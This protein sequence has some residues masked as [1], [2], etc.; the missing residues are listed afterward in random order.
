[1]KKSLALFLGL[2]AISL[3]WNP[4][5]VADEVQEKKVEAYS[6]EVAKIKKYFD[7]ANLQDYSEFS[8]EGDNEYLYSFPDL[9]EYDEND[10]ELDVEEFQIGSI[11][12]LDIKKIHSIFIYEYCID[13]AFMDMLYL[14][15]DVKTLKFYACTFADSVE[16]DWSHFRSL[17]YLLLDD[18]S[19]V[20][21][22]VLK[23][24][25][26]CPKLEAL[27]ITISFNNYKSI[28]SDCN[29]LPALCELYL[30]LDLQK[31][32]PPNFEILSYISKNTREKI[33][34]LDLT[35]PVTDKTA[36]YLHQFPNLKILGIQG[37]HRPD[38]GKTVTD[39]FI[40]QIS[41][42]PLEAL[43]IPMSA[44]TEKSIPVLKEWK[45][46]KLLF[47]S[48]TRITPSQ[49]EEI[50]TSRDWEFFECYPD[51]DFNHDWQGH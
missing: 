9:F 38:V 22:D 30:D 10:E 33:R 6:P 19:K 43:Q 7:G 37:H 36:H 26:M 44:I 51:P 31:G 48:L 28:V 4:C 46:L 35:V 2:L 14:F 41:D 11:K 42:I 5:L 8:A 16:C 18:C 13:S 15:S 50:E 23:S 34:N 27:S 49:M 32:F 12:N 25:P 1:M 17:E 45:S 39:D 47:L 21:S 40:L 24:A 3:S 29:K 20:P